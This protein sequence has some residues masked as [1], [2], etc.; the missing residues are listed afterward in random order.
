[1]TVNKSSEH[2][3][4]KKRIFIVTAL[5]AAALIAFATA[6]KNGNL[7]NSMRLLRVE[8][9]V[10]IEDSKGNNKPVMDNLRFQSGDALTTGSDGLASVGL[11]DTK[12]ITLQNDSRSEFV[13]KGKQLELKL[14]K[15]AVFFNVTEK[16]REDEKFEIKTS[17]MTAGIRGTSGIIYYDSQDNNRQTITVTDGVVEISATNPDTNQTKTVKVEGGNTAKVYFYNNDGT[18]EDVEFQVSE[19]KEDDLARF[20]LNWIADNE[21]LVSR[22]SNFL[23]W[24]KDNLKKALR[25]NSAPSTT[26]TE[27]EPEATSSSTAKATSTTT[28][29]TQDTEPPTDTPPAA[30][31]PK[32][33]KKN[34]KKKKT[35]TRVVTRKPVKRTKK[36]K[37]TNNTTKQTSGSTS[38]SSAK[39]T[40]GTTTPSAETTPRTADETP[41]T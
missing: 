14:T 1:M 34:T 25:G 19:I 6:C 36:K 37:S 39:P 28:G 33:K 40:S 18:H 38:G 32:A 13:K 15:G 10:S 23:N 30:T 5:A 4:L 35:T 2:P 26:E 7:A 11:D 9:T 3:T 31:K 21:E 27:T 22:I 24:D 17:T 16:L 29:D 12:I 41:S 20:N 8:G